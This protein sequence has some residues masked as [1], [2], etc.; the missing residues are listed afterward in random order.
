[1]V[2]VDLDLASVITASGGAVALILKAL[3]TRSRGQKALEVRVADLEAQLLTWATWAHNA[4]LTAAASGCRLP[5]IPLPRSAS[6]STEGV[7]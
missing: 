3:T 4:R 1:M 5:A 2:Q 6:D 7:H